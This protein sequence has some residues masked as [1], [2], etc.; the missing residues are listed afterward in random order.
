MSHESKGCPLCGHPAIRALLVGTDRARAT[1]EDY[2]YGRCEGCGLVQQYPLPFP[3]EIPGLYPE[4]YRSHDAPAPRR[5][6]AWN[7]FFIRYFYGVKSVS[8]PAIVRRLLRALSGRVMPGTLEPHG[9][10]RLL[11]V[12]CGSGGLLLRYRDLGWDVRGIEIS[13]RA[14]EACRQQGLEVHQGTLLERP[15]PARRFDVILLHHVLEHLLEPVDVLRVAGGYLAVGGKVVVVTPH[16]RAW[17]FSFFASCWH[18]LDAPR[19]LMLYDAKTLRL[20][21]E[22][23]GMSLAR[24]KTLSSPKAW[25]ESRQILRTQGRR[26]PAGLEPRRS[27]LESARTDR[28][29][30]ALFRRL[31]SPLSL[32]AAAVGRGDILV[33]EFTEPGK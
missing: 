29:P 17:S 9:L 20:L 10:N 28:K 33:A 5:P 8:T 13:P 21:G 12:G 14:C 6:G 18:H 22:K 16:A 7:R 15:F 1:P 11:D 27:L 4:D 25:Q 23:A 26:L 3:E 2:A 24:L 31:V 30:G 32:A 19:H